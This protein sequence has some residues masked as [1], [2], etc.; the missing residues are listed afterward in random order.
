MH[1][2]ALVLLLLQ[3]IDARATDRTVLAPPLDGK[4]YHSVYPG[5]R[6][7]EEDDFGTEEIQA[8]SRAVGSPLAWVYFSHEWSRGRKF[9][10]ALARMVRDSN[11]V[12]FIRLMLRSSSKKDVPEPVFTAKN[13]A[14]G[15]F[16]RDLEAWGRA[17]AAFG[18]PI[19]AEWGTEM[20]GR[21]FSWSGD[22]PRFAAAFRRIVDV[23]R[24]AGASNI[25]WFFHV[26]CDDVP[27][28]E[29]NRF[30][31]YYPGDAHVDWVGFSA[32][33]AQTPLETETTPFREAVDRCYARLA[34]LAP[35]KPVAVLEFGCTWN[36]SS[37]PCIPWA[38]RALEDLLGGRWP[39]IRAFSWWNEDWVNDDVKAHDT[40]MRVQGS[41]ALAGTFRRALGLK[42][43]K[44]ESKARFSK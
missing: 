27:E 1:T 13:I 29:R 34:K 32:Y 43:S 15:L 42:G 23:T 35:A 30:E 18:S 39:G 22:P 7:E 5:S 19:L 36:H 11:A 28:E 20:N 41:S 26:N 33:G 3:P 21:W 37:L 25:T 16:D 9:P 24:R 12:P 6:G 4:V 31:K 8:Y 10:E 40:R 2:L 38:E 17:A 14:E 44:V